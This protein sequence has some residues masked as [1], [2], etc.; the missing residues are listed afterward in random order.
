MQMQTFH[1]DSFQ[2]GSLQL[3]YFAS[4]FRTF[5]QSLQTCLYFSV[6]TQVLFISMVEMH[7]KN[8]TYEVH[9]YILGGRTSTQMYNHGGF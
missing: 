5:L 4:I 3:N 7:M 1:S 6:F 8:L 9:V 2:V